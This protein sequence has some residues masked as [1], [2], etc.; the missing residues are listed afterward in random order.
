MHLQ[1]SSLIVQKC[2]F[3][4]NHVKCHLYI[5]VYTDLVYR[6]LTDTWADTDIH[7]RIY[8]SFCPL[9]MMFQETRT[10]LYSRD[11][12]RI[13]RVVVHPRE[14]FHNDEC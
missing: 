12:P 11:M 5:R 7:V 13:T 1:M 4:I 2:E 8:G 3:D 9:P 10:C 14:T 6:Y